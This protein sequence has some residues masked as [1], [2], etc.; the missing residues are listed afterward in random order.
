MQYF[1]HSICRT[2]VEKSLVAAI[3]VPFSVWGNV[4]FRV[5]WCDGTS[6]IRRLHH[7]DQPVD[8][9]GICV[10]IFFGRLSFLSRAVDHG[11]LATTP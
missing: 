10:V 7:R 11:R 2:S 1:E 4:C 6:C 8:D 9:V 3:L 5:A